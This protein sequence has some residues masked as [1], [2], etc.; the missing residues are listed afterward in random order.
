[1]ARIVELAR[2]EGY[3]AGVRE[4]R[5]PGRD[6]ASLALEN[7]VEA[8]ERTAE[9][10]REEAA[11]EAAVLATEIA[12]YILHQEIESGRYDV[13][14]VVREVLRESAV[15]REECIVHLN[16]E[17]V[18]SLEG[19]KFRAGTKLVEDVDV[20]RGNVQVSTPRGLM[21]RD[22]DDAVRSIRERILADLR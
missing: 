20:P 2:E 16:P 7:A 5:T 8:L 10:L 18:A 11:R 21:V 14:R 17:D 15:G 3:A 9:E 4:G 13:E 22:V 19:V 1:M 6:A 12:G